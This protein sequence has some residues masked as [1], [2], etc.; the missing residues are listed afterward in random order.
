MWIAPTARHNCF[1][2]WI[3]WE[4]VFNDRIIEATLVDPNITLARLPANVLWSIGVHARDVYGRRAGQCQTL[5]WVFEWVKTVWPEIRLWIDPWGPLHRHGSAPKGPI[6]PLGVPTLDVMPLVDAALGAALV[7][8][9]QALPYPPD[10]L[11]DRHDK[12][13]RRGQRQGLAV[14]RQGGAGRA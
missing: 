8:L 10:K 2:R 14:R 6:G 4:L 7:S 13:R 11:T 12:N 5:E 9:R 1:N 3:W